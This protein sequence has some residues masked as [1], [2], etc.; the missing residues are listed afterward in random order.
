MALSIKSERADQLARDLVALTGESITDAVVAA[1]EGPARGRAPSPCH[2]GD[3]RHR[4]AVRLS[5]RCSTN[6]PPTTSWATTSTGS[7]RD[8]RRH[9]GDRRGALRRGARRRDRTSPDLR[10]LCDVGRH[11]GGSLGIVIVEA[12][13]GPAGTQ[14]LGELL[15]RL[16]V[17][18]VPVGTAARR[19]RHRRVAAFRGAT[20]SSRAEPRRHVLL[21]AGTAA[22]Q[23]LAFV[24]DDFVHTD[25]PVS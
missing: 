24:G 10:A 5:S 12:K 7:R 16:R 19:G 2:V 9:V 14:L 8:R 4:G 18:V 11:P 3:R 1:L 6:V 20:P 13:T 15:D 21:C 25:L 17:E 23:P 22:R